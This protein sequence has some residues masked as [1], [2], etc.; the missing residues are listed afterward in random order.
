MPCICATA[1]VT[2]QQRFPRPCQ[3]NLRTVASGDAMVALW[4]TLFGYLAGSIKSV[5]K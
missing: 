1:Y 5:D 2:R 4:R 3:E